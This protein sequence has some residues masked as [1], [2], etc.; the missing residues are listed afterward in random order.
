VNRDQLTSA[1]PP[2][3]L[4]TP[5]LREAGFADY[6]QIYRLESTFFSDSLPPDARRG[7]FEDNPLWPRL[8]DTWPIGWVLED[9][10]GR[11]VGSVNNIP[12][13]YQLDGNVRI[14]GNGHCW[15]VLDQY[16]GYATM[17]MD[18]YFNQEHS[19]LLVSAKVGAD[20]TPVWSAYAQRV[21][22]GDW[23]TAAYAI[24]RY[25]GFA[26]T[27]LNIKRVPFAG[28]LALPVAAS[29]RLKDALTAK[30]L[31]D[32]PRSVE[33]SEVGG[34]DA[35][36]DAF[37]RELVEQNPGMLLGARDTDSLRW[38]YAIPLRA[39]R[40][41]I[42][43]ATR[44]NVIRAY[45]VLKQHF[46]PTGVRSMKLVDYQTLDYDTDLLPGLLKLAL[47]RSAAENCYV[48]EHHGCGLPKMHSFDRLAN[49]R[50]TKPSWSFY[51]YTDDP[52]LDVRLA[53][54]A[55]WDPSEFDGDSSLK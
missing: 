51:Y 20:A 16:R 26:R 38:H 36:F 4:S 35:R 43:I 23:G 31:P 46:R 40:L 55:V 9:A 32:G 42:L 15:A 2:G 49:Y 39:K 12:S 5:R 25:T 13:S 29:L 28:A 54:P 3:P 48:L 33:Y 7:L 45:C 18:E 53:D 30:A 19:D 44:N 10:D 34:F 22:I 6:P 24:T 50:A 47:R 8:Q 1:P 52:A 14:C 17:L 21:P 27:A 11:I 37:W 41:W